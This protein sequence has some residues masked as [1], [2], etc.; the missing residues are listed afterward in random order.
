LIRVA[1]T[2]RT[3]PLRSHCAQLF[4]CVLR[5]LMPSVASACR[6]LVTTPSPLCRSW[7]TIV[8]QSYSPICQISTFLTRELPQHRCSSSSVRARVCDVA[9]LVRHGPKVLTVRTL[10]PVAWWRAVVSHAKSH[11]LRA[12]AGAPHAVCTQRAVPRQRCGPSLH[13]FCH[14]GSGSLVP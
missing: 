8:P 9:T 6:P 5:V 10:S 7:S 3:L 12:L 14:T 11:A 1:F 4:T 13:T 2:L